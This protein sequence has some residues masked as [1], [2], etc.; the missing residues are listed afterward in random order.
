MF[1]DFLVII[2]HMPLLAPLWDLQPNRTASPLWNDGTTK[3]TH[4]Q[5]SF[6]LGCMLTSR[7]VCERIGTINSQTEK[8][9][10]FLT[11]LNSII[12]VNSWIPLNDFSTE[13]HWTVNKFSNFDPNLDWIRIKWISSVCATQ[14]HKTD[15]FSSSFATAIQYYRHCEQQLYK[16]TTSRHKGIYMHVRSENAELKRHPLRNSLI[17]N[18]Q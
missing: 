12:A 4:S 11:G 13:W 17:L 15:W 18:V 5:W 7:G 8:E 2:H 3:L 1:V 16:S 14:C 6:G 10:R 9:F